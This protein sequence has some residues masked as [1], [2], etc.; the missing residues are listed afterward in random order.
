MAGRNS[1]TRPHTTSMRRY[2]LVMGGAVGAF[3]AAAAMATGSA[4][5]T[6]EADFEDLLDPIIQPFLTSLTDPLRSSTRRRRST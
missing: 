4:S 6:G 1:K 2:G 5:G 3:V